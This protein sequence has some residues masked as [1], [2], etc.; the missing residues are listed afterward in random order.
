MATALCLRPACKPH[1]V[2][3]IAPPGWS[4]LWATCLHAALA[5]YPG[6]WLLAKRGDEQPPA[7]SKR[8]M[9]LLG[10]APGGGCLAAH[11]AVDAGG[12]LHS[13][14]NG[15]AQA[16]AMDCPRLFTIACDC[17]F[18]IADC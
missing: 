11:I 2:R 6:L 5:A 13:E 17:R 4:S 12:L 3:W 9:P 18:L 15:F 10:L 1:S 8:A 7:R 16:T 14:T